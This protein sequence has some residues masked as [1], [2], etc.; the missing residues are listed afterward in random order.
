VVNSPRLNGASVK[1]DILAFLSDPQRRQFL[2]LQ[3]ENNCENAIELLAAHDAINPDR[4]IV[5]NSWPEPS[6]GSTNWLLNYLWRRQEYVDLENPGFIK[7]EN[8]AVTFA[9]PSGSKRGWISRGLFSAKLTEQRGFEGDEV[10]IE[11]LIAIVDATR[12][13]RLRYDGDSPMRDEWQHPPEANGT[14]AAYPAPQHYARDKWIYE[15]IATMNY[16]ALSL[17]IKTISQK[18]R[19]DIITSRN[20]FKDSADRYANFHSLDLKRFPNRRTA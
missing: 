15:K 5:A 2:R 19:W 10:L 18:N 3:A 1:Q 14:P 8:G 11:R 7:E 9:A 17:E 20:G 16:A 12:E 4:R 13:L 6:A